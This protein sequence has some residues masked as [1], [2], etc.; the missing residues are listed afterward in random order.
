MKTYSVPF[1]I[2]NRI[3]LRFNVNAPEFTALT[4]CELMRRQALV[5]E[6]RGHSDLFNHLSE[7]FGGRLELILGKRR[8]NQ[9][10]RE[11]SASQ[12]RLIDVIIYL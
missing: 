10:T 3:S 12:V 5:G 9:L 2:T 11:A 1:G 7:E 4:A 6:A 8:F